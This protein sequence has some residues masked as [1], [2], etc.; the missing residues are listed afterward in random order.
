MVTVAR[1]SKACKS[2]CWWA[3]TLAS[4][5]AAQRDADIKLEKIEEAEQRLLESDRYARKLKGELLTAQQDRE[6]L[7]KAMNKCEDVEKEL[8]SRIADRQAAS[9][10]AD[11]LGQ[12]AEPI[13]QM[14]LQ[15]MEDL[16]EQLA[17][18]LGDSLVS[19]CLAVY[20]GPMHSSERKEA[21]RIWR[22]C[23]EQSGLSVCSNSFCLDT[24]LWRRQRQVSSFDMAICPPT[25]PYPSCS[26]QLT[27]GMKDHALA[28][29]RS[30]GWIEP[31]LLVSLAVRPPLIIDDCHEAMDLVQE[32]NH[33]LPICN[34]DIR[35]DNVVAKAAKA[36]EGG[37]VVIVQIHQPG[38]SH[39]VSVMS[40]ISFVCSRFLDSN[41]SSAPPL[42]R[43]IEPAEQDNSES[44]PR[45]I[46]HRLYFR[47]LSLGSDDDDAGGHGFSPT[48]LS[49]DLLRVISPVLF[50]YERHEMSHPSLSQSPLLLP[51]DTRQTHIAS[52]Q[53]SR[54]VTD[55]LIQSLL[56]IDAS[57]EIREAK[58]NAWEALRNAEEIR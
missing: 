16:D 47:S 53:F 2:I 18:L 17:S 41:G 24:F 25:S 39:E 58:G 26:N 57:A 42:P 33:G 29:V 52:S 10:R 40:A 30:S 46:G 7:I 27:G 43:L 13:T 44:L 23:I 45:M 20:G 4:L 50:S 8:L 56:G 14:W 35:E 55:V 1:V 21:V 49:P 5:I 48:M 15:E 51:K 3:I 54:K 36:I 37:A 9:L 28:A 22:E 38:S 31:L 34:L 32:M 11:L 19:A 12:K 6:Q